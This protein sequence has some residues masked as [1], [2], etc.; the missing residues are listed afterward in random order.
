VLQGERPLAKDNRT[1]G[2]FHLTGIPPAPRGIPQIEVTFDLDANGILTV[3]A[4]DLSTGKSQQIT[5]TASSGLT[6]E[7]VE[8]MVKDAE[9]HAAE[10]A[11]KREEIEVRNATDA[12]VYST[13]HALAEHGTKLSA[14]ERAAV[15]KALDAA[16]DALRGGDMN[17]MRQAQD[18]LRRASQTLMQAAS[19]PVSDSAAGGSSSAGQT[20]NGEVVDAEVLE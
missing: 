5:V 12:L 14:D 10:D 3:S 7:E 16:R 2:R 8:R 19:R 20:A 15:E 11:R 13:Q 4:K 17:A 18:E 6:K 1:L 9:S